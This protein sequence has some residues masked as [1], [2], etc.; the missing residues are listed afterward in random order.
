MAARPEIAVNGVPANSAAL[1]AAVER[2]WVPGETVLYVGL[3]GT[4]VAHRVAQYYSTRLGARSPHA[5]GW[6]IKVLADLDRLYVHVAET[7]APDDAEVAALT[8]FMNCIQ[9]TT[10]AILCDPALPL[11]FAN[12]QLS[13]GVRKHHGSLALDS[14]DYHRTA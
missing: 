1:S 12:L 2:M 13:E 7:D 4:S 5:G 10:R 11:P 6:P 9:Q 8:A 14:R 3:A